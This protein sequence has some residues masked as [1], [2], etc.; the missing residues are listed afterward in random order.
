[1]KRK[2]QDVTLLGSWEEV[3]KLPASQIT[4]TPDEEILN[5][6]ILRGYETKFGAG[7]NEN[8]ERYSKDAIDDFIERYF[9]KNKLNMPVD[10]E[11]DHRPE[12]L[13]GKVL[14]LENND[15]GFYFVSYI[16]ETF[17]HYDVVLNL[18]RQGILQGFSKEGYAEGTIK[19]EEGESYFYIEKMDII[20]VSLVSTPANACTFE[21]MQTIT[22]TLKYKK[23][24]KYSFLK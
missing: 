23:S 4:K 19:E 13:A 8:G 12:W 7:T 5:G 15:T 3:S 24:K 20:R 17:L 6:I 2:I 22:N 10:I 18:L 21:D 1:M 14:Y 16:P 11:H 9:V